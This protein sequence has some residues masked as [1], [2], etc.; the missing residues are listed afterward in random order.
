MTHQRAGHVRGGKLGTEKLRVGEAGAVCWTGEDQGGSPG[1]SEQMA[2]VLCRVG[3]T[4]MAWL[5]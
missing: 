2:G 4:V 1:F 3:M 5:G